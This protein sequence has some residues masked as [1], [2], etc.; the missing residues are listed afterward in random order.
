VRLKQWLNYRLETEDQDGFRIPD[1]EIAIYKKRNYIHFRDETLSCKVRKEE[2]TK[3][4]KTAGKGNFSRDLRCFVRGILIGH[5]PLLRFIHEEWII[6]QDEDYKRLAGLPLDTD[7]MEFMRNNKQESFALSQIVSDLTREEVKARLNLDETVATT[8]NGYE[9]EFFWL[10]C[11]STGI[12]PVILLR[13]GT[14]LIGNGVTMPLI[15]QLA[16]EDFNVRV[17]YTGLTKIAEE[18]GHE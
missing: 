2:Q 16:I 18:C 1:I 11:F 6:M 5:Q 3:A 14:R 10:H 12:S 4:Y 13:I 15:G 7:L 9:K 17:T 8:L